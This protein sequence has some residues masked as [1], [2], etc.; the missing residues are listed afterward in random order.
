MA[1]AL[2]P[3]RN[4]ARVFHHYCNHPSLEGTYAGH[5]YRAF[6][7]IEDPAHDVL[8]NPAQLLIGYRVP[9]QDC[10]FNKNMHGGAFATLVDVCT[11]L[12]IMKVDPH[13]RKNVTIE[14]SESCMSPAQEGDLLLIRA[15]CLRLGQS[16]AFTECKILLA[17]NYKMLVSG[18]QI[19]SMMKEPWDPKLLEIS[20]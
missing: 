4:F 10:N 1:S 14:L 3:V 13:F 6:T 2:K 9:K 20:S 18:R 17:S 16:V 12:A 11:T 5:M 15:E 7:L 19:K 8:H